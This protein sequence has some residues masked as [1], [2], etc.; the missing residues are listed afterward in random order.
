MTPALQVAPPRADSGVG[1]GHLVARAAGGGTV[2]S[3]ARA[4]APLR[5]VQTDFPGSRACSVCVL[6]FGGGLVGGDVIEVDVRVEP[7]ATL[8]LFTQATTKAFRG[9]TRQTLRAHVNGGTLLLLSDPVAPCAGARFEQRTE[10]TLEGDGSCVVLDGFTAGRVAYG[11]RWAFDRLQLTTTVRREHLAF[12]DA[13][14][15]DAAD[16]PLD[17][18]MDRFGAFATLSAIG[19][20][21]A[22]LSRALLAPAEVTE[23][24]VASPGTL[25]ARRGEPSEGAVVR[26]AATT[27]AALTHALQKRLGNLP[28]IGVVDPFASRG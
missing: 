15:L 11:E 22:P 10:V 7:G 20:R 3:A 19:P 17:A 28:D 8:M 24:L 2:L 27:L 6:T 14:R 18:R 12:R 9:A 5:F 1:R 21:V 23:A 26:L 13:L 16:G 25:P 4:S